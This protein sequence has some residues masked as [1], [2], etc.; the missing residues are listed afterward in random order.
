M[1]K[2]SSFTRAAFSAGVRAEIEGSIKGSF[3]ILIKE[4]IESAVVIAVT[5]ANPDPRINR[6]KLACNGCPYHMPDDTC[7]P[8]CD[9]WYRYLLERKTYNEL[10][11]EKREQ[12]EQKLAEKEKKKAQAQ[13]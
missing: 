12:A 3:I 4:P 11:F 13:K 5:T 7:L 8:H 1:I 2:S 6:L 9:S 10:P